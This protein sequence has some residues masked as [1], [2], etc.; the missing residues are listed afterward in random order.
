[1]ALSRFGTFTDL[2]GSHSAASGEDYPSIATLTFDK[3]KYS[4]RYLT[5]VSVESENMQRQPLQTSTRQENRLWNKFTGGSWPFMDV[6][7]RFW[8]ESL[9]TP[10]ILTGKT[11]KQIAAALSRPSSPIAQAVDGSANEVIAAICSVTGNQPSSVCDT[12]TITSIE[13]GL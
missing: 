7:N 3:A 4:S 13:R 6:G 8:T 11:Q 12:G 1:V 9:F 2:T 10:A 5:F